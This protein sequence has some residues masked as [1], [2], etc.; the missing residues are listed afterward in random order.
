MRVLLLLNLKNKIS[1]EHHVET[2]IGEEIHEH[3]EK[4][5][6]M[7]G[8]TTVEIKERKEEKNE[9]MEMEKK[10]TE[11]LEGQKQMIDAESK[12]SKGE[13]SSSSMPSKLNPFAPMFTPI[14]PANAESLYQGGQNQ[15]HHANQPFIPLH[16]AAPHY[17]IIYTP[18]QIQQPQAIH[19][20]TQNSLHPYYQPPHFTYHH[21][22][23]NHAS[24]NQLYSGRQFPFLA[25]HPLSNIPPPHHF[26]PQMPL[27]A[28]VPTQQQSLLPHQNIQ[29]EHEQQQQIPK[30]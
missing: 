11:S 16:P 8:K 14:A 30:P 15:S 21:P 24:Y 19:P 13:S 2:E 12:M 5:T 18:Q 1:D 4:G 22:N 10:D 27:Y 26:Q 29:H 28:T 9:V 17:P 25:I 20:F 23:I 7:E 6:N 3:E